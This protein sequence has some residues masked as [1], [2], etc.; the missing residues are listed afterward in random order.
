[1]PVAVPSI[2]EPALSEGLAEVPKKCG[3]GLVKG[4]TWAMLPPLRSE[5]VEAGAEVDA[6]GKTIGEEQQCRLDV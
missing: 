4:V 3:V 6:I 5:R 1:M 2:D